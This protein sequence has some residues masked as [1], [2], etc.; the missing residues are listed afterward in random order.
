MRQWWCVRDGAHE[1]LNQIHL[2]STAIL[3]A[4]VRCITRDVQEEG[5]PASGDEEDGVDE[6]S[7]DE[8]DAAAVCAASVL[9]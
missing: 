5:G 1:E 9:R 7:A 8:D 3:T 6:D 2:L 4:R